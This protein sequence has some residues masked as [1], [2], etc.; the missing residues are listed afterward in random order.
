MLQKKQGLKQ[1]K[2]CY[3]LSN[4]TMGQNCPRF[5]SSSY[6]SRATY[7]KHL[8]ILAKKMFITCEPMVQSSSVRPFW[9]AQNVSSNTYSKNQGI[10]IHPKL[11]V[12][13]YSIDGLKLLLFSCFCMVS[14]TFLTGSDGIDNL[15]H[16]YRSMDVQIALNAH[17][18]L[19]TPV[20]ET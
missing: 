1:G 12:C 14:L 18:K 20:N 2:K 11:H 7:S 17:F 8:K 16:Q 6:K 9:K 10:Y 13:T 19:E 3:I 5:S 15:M 4:F